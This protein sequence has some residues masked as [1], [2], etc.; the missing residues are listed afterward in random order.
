MEISLIVSIYRHAENLRES[1]A[2]DKTTW[3]RVLP[4]SLV[5][6]L[7]MLVL[8]IGLYLRMNVCVGDQWCYHK[9]PVDVEP[10]TSSAP[11]Q[12]SFELLRSQWEARI[13]IC[14]VVNN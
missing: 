12:T 3:I 2:F 1:E 9:S 14:K 10:K 8:S 6:F 5:T 11:K 7:D 4:E 13:S